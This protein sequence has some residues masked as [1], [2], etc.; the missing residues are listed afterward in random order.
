MGYSGS[1]AKRERAG[2]HVNVPMISG[3][4]PPQV[5]MF[6]DT[7]AAIASTSAGTRRGRKRPEHEDSP[8]VMKATSF[9]GD[10]WNP[11]EYYAE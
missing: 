4:P 5:G 3:A 6:E 1:K 11:F 8:I 2:L 10:E 9:P 7:T